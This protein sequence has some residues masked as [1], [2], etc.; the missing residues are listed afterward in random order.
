[1]TLQ[2]PSFVGFDRLFNELERMNTAKQVSFPPHNIIKITDSEYLLELALAG[3]N[4]DDV[5]IK[6]EK[7]VLTV[8]TVENYTT[9]DDSMTFLHKGISAKKF[10]K[11]FTISENIEVMG[12]SMEDGILSIS[13]QE[14]IPEEKR[15][16]MI[17][18]G[19]SK[20][21]QYLAE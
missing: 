7:G 1:M 9:S 14:I 13:L 12:A 10:R 20:E 16:K 6:L 8:Q 18:I 11:S 5:E 19:R 4:Q 15:P 17:P 2:H 3:Y 21:Q